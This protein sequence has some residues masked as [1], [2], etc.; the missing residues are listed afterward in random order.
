MKNIQ[1]DAEGDV[2][3][4]T[5]V[6]I[7]D[8]AHR[9]VELHDNIILYF[10]LETEQAIKLILLSYYRL[11]E[12]SRQQPLSLDG[13]NLLPES[14]RSKVMRIVGRP[15]VANF[16]HLIQSENTTPTSRL[17][18]VFTPAALRAMAA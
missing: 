17:D 3:S 9:G 10:N 2:L 12:A 1:Y 4:L 18:Q 5:F 8:Q 15:P 16:V 13:L 6:E 11:T 14:M 7:E